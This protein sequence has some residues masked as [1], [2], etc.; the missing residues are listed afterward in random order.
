VKAPTP[1]TH[2]EVDAALAGSGWARD[3]DEIRL[4][5]RFDSFA[6]A[7][8]FVVA[9]GALAESH[10]HHPDVDLRWVEVTLRVTT[11]QIGGLSVR[12]VELARAVDALSW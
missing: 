1:L 11:H 12:D 6:A 4:V 9:V 5:R 3:A 7:L 2:D 8:G 10:D